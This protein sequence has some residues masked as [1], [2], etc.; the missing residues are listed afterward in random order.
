MTGASRGPISTPTTAIHAAHPPF[1]PHAA[2]LERASRP[3]DGAFDFPRA[4]TVA[5]VCSLQQTTTLRVTVPSVCIAMCPFTRVSHTLCVLSSVSPDD[6]RIVLSHTTSNRIELRCCAGA[7][8]MAF[9]TH[10]PAS[11]P[12]SQASGQTD[13]DHEAR[14]QT[15]AEL[16][17]YACSKYNDTESLRRICTRTIATPAGRSLLCGPSI[18]NRDVTSTRFTCEAC[19]RSVAR[20][21]KPPNSTDPT[22]HCIRST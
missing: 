15:C 14:A 3:H 18:R 10:G 8:D 9:C 2:R 5:F 13:G 20:D 22:P 17:W 1:P 7:L 11:Q 4:D 12:A 6:V 19:P 16:S 21:L